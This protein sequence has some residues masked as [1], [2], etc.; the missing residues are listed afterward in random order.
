MDRTIAIDQVEALAN[1][2]ELF[3]GEHINNAAAADSG[4]QNNGAKVIAYN[5]TMIAES[6]AS[7]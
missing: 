7:R 4:S 3:A 6:L 1:A 5:S 2:R